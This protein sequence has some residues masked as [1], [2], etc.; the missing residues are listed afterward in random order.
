MLQAVMALA[1]ATSSMFAGASAVGAGTAAA[2][3]TAAAGGAAAGGTAVRMGGFGQAIGKATELFGKIKDPASKIVDTFKE[4]YESGVALADAQLESNRGLRQW[5]AGINRSYAELEVSRMQNQAK[6]AAATESSASAL[7]DA[8]RQ[9]EQ[10]LLAGEAGMADWSNKIGGF[11]KGIQTG[12]KSFVY[13]ITG[14]AKHGRDLMKAT[15]NAKTPAEAMMDTLDQI[16]AGG[17]AKRRR[18]EPIQMPP[19]STR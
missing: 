7:V 6:L 14:A 15:K 5:N 13:E 11:F 3:G 19:R 17:I 16:A 10:Q 9:Q 2:S 8:Q 4:V 1:S 18:Q 12:L